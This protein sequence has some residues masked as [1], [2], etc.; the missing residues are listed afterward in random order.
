[1]IIRWEDVRDFVYDYPAWSMR[2][3]EAMAGIALVSET[4]PPLKQVVGSAAIIAVIA[5]TG[6]A[7]YAADPPTTEK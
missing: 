1:M 3:T 5:T 4:A 2:C 7:P 6:E